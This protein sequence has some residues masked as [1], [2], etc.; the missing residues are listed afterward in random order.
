MRIAFDLESTNLLDSSSID[1]TVFPYE[2]RDS[3]AVH[4]LVAKD[5]DSGDLYRFTP[6]NIGEIPSFM[7]GATE[8]IGHNIINYDCLVLRLYFGLHFKVGYEGDD[9]TLNGKPIKITDTLVLSRMLNP[10]RKGGH[11]LKAWGLRTGVLKQGF[12]ETADWK[13]YTEEMLEYCVDDV[14][15]TEA[16]YKALCKEAQGWDWRLAHNIE[17]KIAELT[18]YQ[19]HFGFY[20]DKGLAEECLVELDQ[21]LE[22]ITARVEPQL[23]KKQI[24]KTSAKQYTPPKVQFKKNGELSANMLKF[25]EKMGG[26]VVGK[27]QAEIRGKVY[28]LPLPLEPLVTTEPMQMGN[29]IEMKQWLVSLGWN[30]KVWGEKDLTLD[31]NK[32][33]QT[34]EKF[35]QSAERYIEDTLNSPYLDYRCDRLKCKPFE[36]R[37]KILN[38]NLNRPLKVYTSPKYTINADKD[39]DPAL[40]KLGEDYKFVEDVVKWLTYRHRR[41]SILSPKGTGFLK[42]Y[43]EDG[44]IPTPA[45]PCGASTSRYQHSV[46][47]NI[48]RVTSEYGDKMRSLFGCQP[49]NFQVGYDFSGL[50]A[51]IEAHYTKQFDGD[52][53]ALAL[54]SEKPNDIHTVNAQK[55]GVT[56]DEAKTMKYAVTYGAQAAKIA[57]QMGWSMQKAQKIFDDFWDA[58][59]PLQVLK[60]RVSGYWIKKGGKE[61]VK[62]IDGRKLWV[63]S[64]HSILNIIFQSAGVICAKKANILHHKWLEERG[65]LFDPFSD[66]SF[67]GKC[68]A[69]THYHDECQWEVHHSL[70]EDGK[71]VVGEL[72]SKAAYEAGDFFGL[73][74][75]LDADYDVGKNWKDCH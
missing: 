12:G 4:C 66:S 46:V 55:V 32:Q 18:T 6:E 37:K 45:N 68:H 17:K 64:E 36:L 31:S 48:P 59:M 3:F 63:R 15:A 27:R 13:E 58:A 52:A 72:A 71:S 28:D 29:Q 70:V 22:D 34:K 11:S 10:D 21:W 44:R 73:R 43:R 30:P 47:C 14:L 67:E 35:L 23:P 51:R 16:A 41:N 33:K 39:I 65:L 9:D 20:F 53:Y 8:V 24:S 26:S 61:F 49:D 60:E 5:I 50:E 40:A 57:S 56:R 75:S 74:V 2:L 62:A 42:H 25:I 54:V 38:H 19:E 1:Y 69:Q 7:E